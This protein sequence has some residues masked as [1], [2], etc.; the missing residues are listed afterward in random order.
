MTSSRLKTLLA[1]GLHWKQIWFIYDQ[2]KYH[3]K[4][5]KLKIQPYIN[6]TIRLMT[7]RKW[8]FGRQNIFLMICQ[9]LNRLKE[10]KCLEV[11]YGLA[12]T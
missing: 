1:R 12:Q 4:K 7:E 2:D 6:K 9:P 3:R 10:K 11:T 8:V 5:V